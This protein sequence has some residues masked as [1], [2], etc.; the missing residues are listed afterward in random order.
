MGVLGTGCR[1]VKHGC[2]GCDRLGDSLGFITTIAHGGGTGLSLF[3]GSR[4]PWWG[5]VGESCVRVG[6]TGCWVGTSEAGR[7]GA[8]AFGLL[9]E[10]LS[11]VWTRPRW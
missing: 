6:R 5:E 9:D 2:L 11:I 7:K 1:D 10:A 8:V 3:L 4:R